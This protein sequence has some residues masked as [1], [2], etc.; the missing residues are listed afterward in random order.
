MKSLLFTAVLLAAVAAHAGDTKNLPIECDKAIEQASV[1]GAKKHYNFQVNG[2]TMSLKERLGTWDTIA[3]IAEAKPSTPS[4]LNRPDRHLK[5]G[6]L[7]FVDKGE[8]CEITSDGN[9]ADKVLKDL[10][11]K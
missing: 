11:K 5:E 4:G 9:P 2:K 8:G 3:A 1:L 6:V 7:V 10:T